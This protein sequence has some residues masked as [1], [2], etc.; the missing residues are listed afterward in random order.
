MAQ[1]TINPKSPPIVWSTVEEAFTAINANFD[2][3]YATIGSELGSVVD[4]STLNSNVSPAITE[5][6]DL[7]SPSYR[8]KDLYLSAGSLY[9]GT[10]V[11]NATGSI[12][13]L[14]AGSTI[15]GSL[16][17]DPIETSFKVISVTG[18]SDIVA[19]NNTDSVNIAAG[20]AGITLTTNA[21]TDTLTITNSGILNIVG[22]SNQIGVSVVSGTAT[23]TNL[24]VLDLTGEAGGI[25]IS[26]DGTG[27]VTITNLGVKQITA[28]TGISIS[29]LGGTGTVQINNEGA[30]VS[31]TRVVVDGDLS[32]A[33]VADGSNDTLNL[34]SGAGITITKNTATD[35]ITITNTSTFSNTFDLV[36]SVFADDSTKLVDGVEAKIVG[37]VEN[38][39]VTT[40]TLTVF[41]NA[42]IND[43]L[44][45]G[46]TNFGSSVD[47][48]AII[49]TSLNAT[50][51][52]VFNDSQ[53]LDIIGS[54]FAD[55]STMLVD[56]T[57]GQ[58]V[59]PINSFDGGNSITMTPLGVIIGGTGGASIIGAATAP[60]YIGGGPS[61]SSSGDVYIGNGTNRTLFVSN[62]ID[63]DDSSALIFDPAVVFRTTVTVDGDLQLNGD[64]HIYGSGTAGNH[65]YGIIKLIPD[66][67][68]ETSNQYIV[69]DPTGPNHIH[70]R[71]GG[72]VDQSNIE[73]RLGGE[74]TY[75]SV[76]DGSESGDGSIGISVKNVG[77]VPAQFGFYSDG[78]FV[79]PV[80]SSAP[81][82]PNIGA[83]YLADGVT[84]DPAAKGGSPPPYH[85]AWDGV[86][87][88]ALY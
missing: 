16:I 26:G 11:I 43:A 66:A 27:N 23:L 35:T 57:N 62:T 67:T 39:S 61:G 12:V 21:S 32:N 88:N 42:V 8:W 49:G 28:G 30:L 17:K 3:L 78:G 86:T 33:V 65:G 59:G 38:S 7:G 1:K 83:I 54:V 36:G 15:G 44:F 52:P 75:V 41:T 29:P 71:A 25:G 64:N 6:Y 77:N 19:E 51:L 14:P 87:F 31:F 53:T 45:T 4:F 63:T 9:L 82:L 18:Q 37:L 60:I 84:W 48:A 56:G 40:N 73:I 55:D 70:I 13:N 2:E 22:T 85:V 81:A 20:N 47:W 10:A 68:L 34:A 58:I 76:Y 69:L 72:V 24:G 74:E 5:T 50:G 46:T 80:L 79:L